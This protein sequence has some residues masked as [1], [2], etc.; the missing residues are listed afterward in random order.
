MKKLSQPWS[1]GALETEAAPFVILQL[2]HYGG[3]RR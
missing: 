2:Y 1:I 3:G